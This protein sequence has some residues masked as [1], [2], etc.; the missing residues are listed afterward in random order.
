M[1][2]SRP[3]GGYV[4]SSL[5]PG[6]Y[7]ITV[8]KTGFRTAIRFGVKLNPSQ[9]ARVDFKLVVG[10]VQETVTVEGAA[11]LLNGDDASVGVLVGRDEMERLPL[12]GGAL[13]SVLQLAPGVL[14]TPATRG[15]AGQFTVNGQ[16]PNTNS[17]LVDGVR[18]IRA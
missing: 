17:F 13:L 10:S 5:Q 16:R 4:V 3:D 6:V 15:E 8:R 7:K 2:Q 11:P 18:R 1:T 9:P 12:N 14:I